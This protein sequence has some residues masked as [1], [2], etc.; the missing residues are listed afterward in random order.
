MCGISPNVICHAL[1]IKPN[2]VSIRYKRRAMDK[3]KYTVLKEEVRKMLASDFINEL[4]YPLWVSNLILVKKN[5][6]EM[7]NLC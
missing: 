5:K 3:E 1:N 4:Y 7:E 6:R 2:V